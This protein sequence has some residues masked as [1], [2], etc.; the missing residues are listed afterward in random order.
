MNNSTK[1]V[2]ALAGGYLLGRS[3]KMRLAVTMA[4]LLAGRKLDLSSGEL[5]ERGAALVQNSP[6]L[7]RLSDQVRGKL[8][9]A[10]KAAAV[11]AASNRLNS[12]SDTLRDRSGGSRA[13][14]G[15]E[16][17]AEV[18]AEAEAE[19]E[20]EPEAEGWTEDEDNGQSPERTRKSP[21]KKSPAKRSPAKKSSARTAAAG[22][23]AAGSRADAGRRPAKKTAKRASPSS[24][25]SES[26]RA[27]K[28]TPAKQGSARKSPTKRGSTGASGGRDAATRSTRSNRTGR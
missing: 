28:A 4:G 19:P 16:D 15:P 8:L 14:A 11:A 18:E 17:E 25:G 26:G 13:L 23:P 20:A 24:S 2:A 9:E 7:S 10:A 3:K 22:K 12:V 6:E 1:T 27:R 21:A 5:L